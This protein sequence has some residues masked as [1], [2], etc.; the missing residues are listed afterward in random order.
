MS[1]KLNG[2]NHFAISV[3]SMEEAAAWYERVL[4]FH[5][6]HIDGHEGFRIG[7]MLGAGIQ[8]EIFELDGAAP[9]PPERRIP[10]EDLL[11][12]G[13]KHISFGVPDGPAAKAELEAMGVDVVMVAETHNTYGV[14]IRD[15]VGNLIEIF[16]ES[17]AHRWRPDVP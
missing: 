11:T 17:E 9:L 2:V 14:F 3:P 5:M 1:I 7:H 4:G 13:N 15:N 8:L 12:H 16:D 10:N 6:D